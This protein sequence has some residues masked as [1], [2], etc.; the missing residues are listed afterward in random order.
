MEMETPTTPKEAATEAAPAIT[1]M[2]EVSLAAKVMLLAEIPEAPCPE[3]VE[4]PSPSM[5]ASTSMPI[6]FSTIAPE[7]L[8]PMPTVP[9][10]IAI[11]KENTRALMVWSASAV[12]V[13]A[14]AASM[15]ELMI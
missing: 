15:L 5:E 8:P 2:S 1:E 9:P 13:S 3:P 14:P 6:L 12:W 7:P 10:A 11:E 4:G